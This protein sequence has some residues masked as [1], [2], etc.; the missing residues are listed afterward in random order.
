M[1]NFLMTC[2]GISFAW[3]SYTLFRVAVTDV[4]EQV[5]LTTRGFRAWFSVYT[6]ATNTWY[7]RL[8]VI[9]D[10]AP[11]VY[12]LLD[13]PGIPGTLSGA[14]SGEQ[15]P[16]TGLA[17]VLP[18]SRLL[19]TRALHLRGWY[20]ASRPLWNDREDIWCSYW[21]S[22]IICS[23]LEIISVVAKNWRWILLTN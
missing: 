6:H 1:A 15:S 3:S 9:A 13:D 21:R 12:L 16:S 8:T 11:V 2:I 7:R 14:F 19:V 23:F 18:A 22:R 4:I 5:D 10:P 17:I 20:L